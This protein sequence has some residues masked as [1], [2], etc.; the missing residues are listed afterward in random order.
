MTVVAGRVAIIYG[1]RQVAARRVP[2]LLLG[3][4]ITATSGA[5]QKLAWSA[6]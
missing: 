6:G 4:L 1:D 3:T 5:T 2:R